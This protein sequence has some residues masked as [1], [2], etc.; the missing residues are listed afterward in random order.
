M[1]GLGLDAGGHSDAANEEGQ[2]PYLPALALQ[3]KKGRSWR[4]SSE[5]AVPA[6]PAS[7]N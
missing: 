5:G 3:R 6:K 4:L 2:A 1:P 7:G